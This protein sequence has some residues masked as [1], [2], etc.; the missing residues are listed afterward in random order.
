[1]APY[2]RGA[3]DQP[4]FAR[5]D[6]SGRVRARCRIGR[7]PDPRVTI[8]TRPSRARSARRARSNR[9]AP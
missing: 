4:L 2:L 7:A 1:M 3:T 5:A 6:L 8:V 9:V